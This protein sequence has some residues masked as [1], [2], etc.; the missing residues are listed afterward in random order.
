METGSFKETL[1]DEPSFGGLPGRDLGVQQE[2][3]NHQ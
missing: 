2:L 3:F 1:I